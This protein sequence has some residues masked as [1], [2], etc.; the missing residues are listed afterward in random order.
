MRG[1]FSPV[2]PQ[3][4]QRLLPKPDAAN[5]AH[6]SVEARRDPLLCCIDFA[7]AAGEFS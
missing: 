1:V 4:K 5:L 7:F 3:S 6:Y 2:S